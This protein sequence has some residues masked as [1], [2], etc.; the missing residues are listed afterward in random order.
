MKSS[1]LNKI[2]LNLPSYSCISTIVWL[3]FEYFY[4]TRG[5][6]ARWVLYYMLFWTNPGSSNL[7]N[8]SCMANYL[9]SSKSPKCDEQY[10]LG[11]AGES[12]EEHISGI[13]Q[14]TSTHGHT[15]DDWPAKTYIHQLCCHDWWLIGT[16]GEKKS[17]ESVLSVRL[18][19]KDVVKT[20]FI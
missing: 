13:L 4:K 2:K 6:K 10:M 9:P 12:K 5:E 17:R 16:D 3:H 20:L 11:T 19:D 15:S 14:W 18:D 1:P 7:E 8:R